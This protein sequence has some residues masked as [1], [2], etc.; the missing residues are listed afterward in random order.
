MANILLIQPIPILFQIKIIRLARIYRLFIIISESLLSDNEQS[1][2][3]SEQSLLAGIQVYG[4]KKS[5]E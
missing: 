5:M 1:L 2:S 3:R 4:R